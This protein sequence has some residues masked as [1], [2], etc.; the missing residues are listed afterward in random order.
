MFVSLCIAA[1]AAA[2]TI[3]YF[4][5]KCNHFRQVI[6][7]QYKLFQKIDS[8][9]S[10]YAVEQVLGYPSWSETSGVLVASYYLKSPP[11]QWWEAPRFVLA[12]VK[13]D[14]KDNAVLSMEYG[15][16]IPSETLSPPPIAFV[17][18]PIYWRLCPYT[19]PWWPWSDTDRVGGATL[20]D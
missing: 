7:K 13:V 18:A 15:G 19:E 9:M 12:A 4:R 3:G 17:N 6:L 11:R 1:I 10:R 16:S 2:G 5:L 14:Y 8:G 20:H